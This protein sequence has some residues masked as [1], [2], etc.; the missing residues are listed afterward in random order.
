MFDL[1]LIT[2]PGTPGGLVNA[3]AE[4]LR[5]V[6]PGRVAVQLRAKALSNAAL[7]PLA[8]A[9]RELTARAGCALLVNGSLEVAAAVGADGAHLPEA[10]PSIAQ[11]R[12]RLGAG[13]LIGV[14][15]HDAASLQRAAL[16]QASF[17][18]LSP[19]FDSPGK[20]TALGVAGF[21]RLAATRRVPVF[22]L[23]GVE[24][25][26][27]RA[28]CAAGAAGIAVIRAVFAATDRKRAVGECLRA[29]DDARAPT[30][31]RD[32]VLPEP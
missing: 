16:E 31:D 19:V 3:V 2:D 28:L 8:G 24:A 5:D 17:A 27:A 14:S 11:A 26:H 15:C 20:G 6:P 18:T 13:A 12:Q 32:D 1:Y 22:A 30:V 23:G 7:L 29:L 10:G 4:A 25:Q 21:A 9:L